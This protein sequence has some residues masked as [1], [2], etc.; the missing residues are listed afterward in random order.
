MA[1]DLSNLGSMLQSARE[2]TLE[3]ANSVASRLID[4]TP[5]L[6]ADITQFLNSRNDNKRLAGMRQIISVSVKSEVF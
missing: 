6:H 5:I 2:L 4:E 3:A 1:G